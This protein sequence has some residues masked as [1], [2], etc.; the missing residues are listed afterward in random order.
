MMKK[1][2]MFDF[3]ITPWLVRILYWVMQVII[4]IKALDI[5]TSQSTYIFGDRIDNVAS[6]WIIIIFGSAILRLITE[7]MI[8]GFRIAKDIELLKKDD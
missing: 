2:L 7:I 1:F 8:L 3:L 4:I 5:M 6:G